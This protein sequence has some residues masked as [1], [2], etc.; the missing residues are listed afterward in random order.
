MLGAY[1]SPLAP[2]AVL[3]LSVFIL[4]VVI[5]PAHRGIRNFGASGLVGVAFLSLLGIRLT[6]GS[7]AMGAGLELLSGWNFSTAESAA[8]LTVRA[9]TLSLPFLIVTLLVLLAVTLL[10]SDAAAAENGHWTQVSGWL[11]MGAGACLLFVSANGL[12]QLYAVMV[13]DTFAAFYWLGRGHRN[14]GVARLFLGIFT[15][16][17][18]IL[19]TLTPTIGAVPGLLLLGLAL[20]LR[21]GLYPFMEATAHAPWRSDERL[22]YLSLSLTVGMYLVIRVVS[23]PLPEII[24]WLTVVAMLLGGLLTW[25]TGSSLPLAGDAGKPVGERRASLLAWLVFTEALLILAAR[26]LAT[27]TAIAFAVGLILSLVALWVTPALGR[28]RLSEGAW[29]WPYL[30]AVVATLTLIGAPLLLGLP[31]RVAIYQSLFR[32]DKLTI[33]LIV[34]LAEGLAL[35]GLIRYWLILGQGNEAGGRRSVVGIVA[36]VPFL[37]PGLAPFILSAITEIELSLGGVEWSFGLLGINIAIVLGAVGLGYF[38]GQIIDRLE[39]PAETM[40]RLIR[41][42][43]LLRW[44]E[45]RLNQISKVALRVRVT[46]EGQHYL[47]WAVFT[48]LVGALIILLRT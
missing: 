12:T 46:L 16:A 28:P 17:G 47:G 1:F 20:W 15:A 19:A 10:R 33:V 14:L 30:P 42:N 37:T 7:D 11:L 48:A 38:R 9:D 39:I 13:F 24:R 27:G 31:A 44:G 4:P 32:I 45:S 3:L 36:M 21:L 6:P 34:I 25:L 43:W 29:S 35:S 2:A 22:A 40:V 26:P 8:A 5:L 18:L 23:E 41:L